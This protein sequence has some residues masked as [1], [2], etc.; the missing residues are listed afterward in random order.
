MLLLPKAFPALL[1]AIR[2]GRVQ[3]IC[4][5]GEGL[6]MDRVPA[7]EEYTHAIRMMRIVPFCPQRPILM[8]STWSQIHFCNESLFIR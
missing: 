3:G 2:A 1:T 4:H 5:G 7:V 8:L 6:N